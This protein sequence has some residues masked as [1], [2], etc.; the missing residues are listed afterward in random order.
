MLRAILQLKIER[1][2]SRIEAVDLQPIR[3]S[4]FSLLNPRSHQPHNDSVDGRCV[5]PGLQ[6]LS[7]LPGTVTPFEGDRLRFRVGRIGNRQR[8]DFVRLQGER[9]LGAVRGRFRGILLAAFP[10]EIIRSSAGQNGQ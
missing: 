1:H 4:R 6:R 9:E 7:D 3:C 8:L 2:V 10:V 5:G